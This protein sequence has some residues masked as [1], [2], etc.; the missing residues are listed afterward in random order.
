V[1]VIAYQLPQQSVLSARSFAAQTT[2][3]R[4]GSGLDVDVAMGISLV[5][6][7]RPDSDCHLPHRQC[8]IRGQE[9]DDSV[10]GWAA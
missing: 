7:K 5:S 10:K 8:S 3:P 1:F 4:G 2:S 6:W 9:R